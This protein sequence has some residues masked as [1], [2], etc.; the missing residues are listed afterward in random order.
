[1]DTVVL[2]ASFAPLILRLAWVVWGRL[3]PRRSDASAS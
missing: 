1:M 3:R 2:I